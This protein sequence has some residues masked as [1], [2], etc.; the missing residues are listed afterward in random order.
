MTTATSAPADAIAA[1]IDAAW[2]ADLERD[3]RAP[4]PH[5]NVWASAHRVCLR[6]MVLELTVPDQAPPWPAEALQRMRRGGDRERDLLA[7]L[8]RIGRNAAPPFTIIGQQEHFT[9]RDRKGR[10]AISGKVD[11]R[12]EIERQRPPIEVKAWSPFI[13]D[14]LERFADVF[15]NPWTAAGG[16][17]LLSYL[18]G[19]GE[20]YGYLLLDRSGIPKLLP[21]ELYQH[22][23]RV[24]TFL[25][26]AELALDHV[27]AA[28]LPDY[29][30]DDPAECVRCPFYGGACNPPLLAPGAMEILSDP[31]LEIALARRDALRA[32][33]EEFNDL[34]DDLKKRCRGITHAV[35]GAFELRGRWSKSSR[36]VLPADLK[37]QYTETNPRGRFTLEI[38]KR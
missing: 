26:R 7:D 3:R 9:L 18:F 36:V 29:L 22:L 2:R 5:R 17:Q 33:G 38:I 19:A 28:T 35:V 10:I 1:T 20:P 11:A 32:A 4:T 30:A 23:D 14:R 21:V 15:D 34:D 16:Y 6:R 8:T 27:D 37:A 13:V 24:E 12:I 31:E 25:T